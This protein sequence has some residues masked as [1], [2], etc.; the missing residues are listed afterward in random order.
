[1]SQPSGP[2]SSTASIASTRDWLLSLGVG[3]L[4]G[5]LVLQMADRR[6]DSTL[7]LSMAV[8]FVV[9]GSA[10]LVLAL[11]SRPHRLRPSQRR[12][13]IRGWLMAL[14]LGLLAAVQLSAHL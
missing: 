5:W 1:M 7:S 9:S 8:L 4:M 2:S 14:G 6:P 3:L 11:L 10:S 13:E 12:G